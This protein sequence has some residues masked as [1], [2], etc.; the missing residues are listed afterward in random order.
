MYK[1][2]LRLL[3]FVVFIPI[4]NANL[5]RELMG[6]DAQQQQRQLKQSE[7][8]LERLKPQA[9]V[10]LD[11][12][13]TDDVAGF[14]LKESNCFS[15][16]RINFVDYQEDSPSSASQFDWAYQKVIRDLNL[17]LPHCFGGDGISALAKHIQHEILKQGYITTQVVI[18][19][20]DLT[21]GL[22][23]LMAVPGRLRHTLIEDNSNV[24]R[25]TRFQ[26][27]NG[28]TLQK[29]DILQLRDLEQSLEN[30]KRVPT[31]EAN[32]EIIPSEGD[33][34]KI[35]ESDVKVSYQ[36]HFP[37]RFVL[38]L[39]DAGSKST[40]KWQGSATLLVDNLL[41]IND[42]FYAYFLHSIKRH[43]DDPGKRGNRN[44]ILYYSVPFREWNLTFSQNDNRY[45]QE[46]F[47]SDNSYLYSGKSNTSRLTLSRVIYR[48]AQRKTS[49]S[50]GIWNRRTYNYIDNTEIEVQRR[51]MSGWEVGL[52]HREYWGDGTIDAEATFKR[53]TGANG[54][55]RAPEE[56]YGEGTSRPKILSVSL[57]YTKPFKWIE[58][59]FRLNSS[60][61]QQ[62]SFMP[63]IA[64]DQFS[65][66]GRYTVRGFDGEVSLLGNR[67]WLWRNDVNWF[68]NHSDHA[69]Y[70]A[71]D[72]GDVRGTDNRKSQVGHHLIGGVAGL[73]GH[74][75]GLSY[76]YFI[77][78]PIRKPQ[79][80]PTSKVVT[81]FNL[82]YA[83]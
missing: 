54:S 24:P 67:G 10:R 56:H 14:P 39:D 36:Q 29:G 38:G 83:F 49:A 17:E 3:P 27:W 34:V 12:S 16:N 60:W 62:W 59:D 51:N 40:G 48:D 35:G 28:M 53:G 43:S 61:N 64:Q 21:N 4:A 26:V 15:V 79:S 70:V 42:L 50:F 11:I 31:V 72:A 74:W 57:S 75:K 78:A 7:T 19:E 30:F 71:M 55:L 1:N 20:Q 13:D 18:P 66:G 80:F 76:D 77:G 47:N 41:S 25:F 68:I 52:S 5:Q 58:Q 37:F 22:L 63:L 2:M 81:G 9:D 33:G 6:V 23:T 32:I 73:K 69:F 8:Q 82:N 46:I 65:I 45:K 44:L